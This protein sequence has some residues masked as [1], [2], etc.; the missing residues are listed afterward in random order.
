VT[1]ERSSA[2]AL[3]RFVARPGVS[4]P[5]SAATSLS[6]ESLERS[7]L[8]AKD[9]LENATPNGTQSTEILSPQTRTDRYEIGLKQGANRVMQSE[10]LE[11]LCLENWFL[12]EAVKA[13]TAAGLE[14]ERLAKYW[15][16]K[17]VEF[18]RHVMGRK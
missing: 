3:V 14:Q 12:K 13:L 11:N 10:T 9:G 17:C 16:R 6:P 7:T 2:S 1:L 15:Q 18:A 8:R 5:S 4:V